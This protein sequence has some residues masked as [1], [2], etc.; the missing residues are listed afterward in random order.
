MQLHAAAARGDLEGMKFA[1]S[2][3]TDVNARNSTEQTALVFALEQTQTFSRRGSP[4]LTTDAVRFLIE[5]GADL[6]IPDSL[7]ATAIHHAARIA[8]RKFMELIL[9]GGGKP[10][11]I[12]K[13]GYSVMTHACYQPSG[14]EKRAIVQKFHALGA[15]LDTASDFGEFPLG[16]CLRFGDFDTMRLLVELGAVTGPL[17]WS[18]LHRAVALEGL[19]GLIA[20]TPTAA[21]INALNH[22]F[23]Q[24]PWLLAFI[25][26]DLDI[27]RW[28]TDQGADLTQTGRCGEGLL[29][30]A[31]R[32]GH[33]G[34]VKWLLDFGADPNPLNEFGATPL[35]EAAEGDHV[36]CARALMER[37]ASSISG[38][39][40]QSQAIH[41]AKSWAMI[42]ALVGLGGAD[43]NA[44]DGCGEWPLKQA[45]EANDLERIR[46]LLNHGAQVDLTSTGE[47]ALHTAVRHDSRE[48]VEALLTAGANP[49]QQ[50][51]DGW[52][53]LFGAQ[54]REVVFTLRRAGAEPRIT[55]QA[56]WG[57]EKWLKDPILVSALCERP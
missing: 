40:V 31:A 19:A 38:N 13:S 4:L 35:H 55:D 12:T 45:A 57:P 15:S 14:P 7:G 34:A 50:D 10:R 16:V 21:V 26:G 49:N 17:N 44:V 52:T 1:L 53:P 46:W 37:G 5:A 41:A 33:L 32:F 25:R 20:L 36:D 29:H 42:Q 24:S 30:I 54:S 47:T 56:A 11:H 27:I 23:E 6:E 3:G 43:I 22:R 9:E 48:A 39:H 18:A 2:Q 8:G 28:L 51:V